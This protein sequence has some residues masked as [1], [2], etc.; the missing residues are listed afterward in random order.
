MR[1]ETAQDQAGYPGSVERVYARLRRHPWLVD[2][3]LAAILLAGAANAFGNPAVLP[4][5]LALAG[6]VLVRQRFPV[7]AYAVALAIGTAQ[8]TF[9]IGAT[10]TDS[11][12]QPTFADVGIL[13]LLYTLAAE[14]PRRLS[15]PGLAACVAL[16]AAAVARYNPGG[17]RPHH[18]MEFALVT[19]LFYLLAPVSAW[20]L[21][22]SMG[23]RRAYSAA[24]ED[25]AVRAERERDAQAQIATAAERA[26]IARELHDVIAHNLSVMVAQADGGAYAFDATPERSRQALA[27]I[28]RTGRQALG[29]MSSL[30]GVLRADPE[31]PLT[32]A[33]AAAEIA[34]LVAQ[35]REAG[36]R[37]SHTVRRRRPPPARWA[38]ARGLPDRAGGAHQRPQARRAGG[39]SAG[40]APLRPPRADYP[41][42]RRRPRHRRPAPLRGGPHGG[43]RRS[44][45]GRDAGA[46]RDIRRHRPGRAPPR[47]RFPGDGPP[48]APACHRAAGRRR[49]ARRRLMIRVLLVDDQDLVRA[50]FAMVLGSQPDLAVV[51][52]AAD[53]AA[54]VRLARECPADVMV[55]D[56]RMP[57]LD[58]IA[59][60]REICQAPERPRVL[61]LTTF[62]LDEY[63]FAALRAGASGFL[64][65]SAPPEELLYAIRCVHNGDSVVAPSTTRRLIGRF[66]P[67]LPAPDGLPDQ[68][69]LAEL[70]VREREVLAEVGSGL[71][72]T[73]IAV[74]L[75]ISEATVKTHVGHI[76]A[77]LGLR[78]RIQAVVYAYETGLIAPQGR[79]NSG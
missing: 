9:G 63:A 57:G 17:D 45:A 6:T 33:P 37:V 42:S 16:F 14:R 34:Q 31:A 40:D 23:Y 60:T 52:E 11:P 71:S 69:G 79:A 20:V 24:L 25:R 19:A 32:P 2:G 38:V 18:P 13:V 50:G 10:F 29:E 53:G 56:V 48:P 76:L 62:D 58:G 4:A 30:L 72:N 5:S 67:H 75:H 27:E 47:R 55:M 73:E 46:G 8:V 74:L 70:T 43:S 41:C 39:D 77:K 28:G 3:T 44:R 66:L 51:G 35:A 78:D 36:M 54:A 1:E 68:Q 15:L 22:D 21:G 65:K 59:A 12:L 61:I 7:A 64:L 26:R 49:A